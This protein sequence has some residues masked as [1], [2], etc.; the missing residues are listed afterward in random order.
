MARKKTSIQYKQITIDELKTGMEVRLHHKIKDITV[1]EKEKM[2]KTKAEVIIK[3]R[4]QVFEGLVIKKKGTK[5]PSATFTIRKISNGIGVEKI[6]PL[7][8]PLITKIELIK[9]LRTSRK[10]LTFMRSSHRKLKEKKAIVETKAKTV[11]KTAPKEDVSK[12]EIN[13]PAVADLE[14]AEKIEKASPEVKAEK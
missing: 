8:S 11:K 12:E 10:N 2:K 3:E 13:E 9:E 5:P 14:P 6:F 4:V 1:P 7:Y